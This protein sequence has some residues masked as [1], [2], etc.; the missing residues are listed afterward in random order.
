MEISL[1]WNNSTP[2]NSISSVDW[3]V[4]TQ[5]CD[6]ILHKQFLSGKLISLETTVLRLIAYLAY[7]C[8]YVFINSFSS[9]HQF[10]PYLIYFVQLSVKVLRCLC[11]RSGFELCIKFAA[12]RERCTHVVVLDYALMRHEAMREVIPDTQEHWHWLLKTAI[13]HK[14]RNSMLFRNHFSVCDVEQITQTIKTLNCLCYSHVS[15][16]T[17]LY[18]R[19]SK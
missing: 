12:E 1:P 5:M 10:N 4:L 9:L 8:D 7:L 3:G 16:N 2:L 18:V 17:S 11:V 6:Y 19:L 15:G 13:L 14:S